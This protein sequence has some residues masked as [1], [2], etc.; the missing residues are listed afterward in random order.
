[1]RISQLLKLAARPDPRAQSAQAVRDA[2]KKVLERA[3]PAYNKHFGGDFQVAKYFKIEKRRGYDWITADLWD[4]K[5]HADNRGVFVSFLIQVSNGKIDTIFPYLK[6][7]P[8]ILAEGKKV[9]W[10][11][12]A[13]PYPEPEALANPATFFAGVKYP[14]Y[15]EEV[16][17]HD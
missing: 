11:S 2:V 5:H 13:E 16:T 1:M 15:V 8:D 7:G 4:T 10:T 9:R 14:D 3:L 6:S 17:I 12:S